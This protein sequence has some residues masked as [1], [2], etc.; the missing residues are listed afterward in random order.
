MERKAR[1]AYDRTLRNLARLHRAEQKAATLKRRYKDGEDPAEYSD[2]SEPS[3]GSSGSGSAGSEPSRREGGS[4]TSARE[5]RA[6]P[7]TRHQ[8]GKILRESGKISTP[9]AGGANGRHNF[10]PFL[11]TFEAVLHTYAEAIPQTMHARELNH[12]LTGEASDVAGGLIAQCLREDRDFPDYAELVSA[13]R[14]QYQVGGQEAK[15]AVSPETKPTPSV[16]PS[17]YN[18]SLSRWSITPYA[19]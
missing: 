14:Q 1:V 18:S 2:K 6:I 9:F 12:C 11:R 16:G 15:G 13:L 4:P 3:S 7:R 17:R 5:S 8:V 10:I 19:H